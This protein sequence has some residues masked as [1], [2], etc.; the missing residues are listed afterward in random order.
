MIQQAITESKYRPIVIPKCEPDTASIGH[1]KQT[2]VKNETSVPN[3]VPHN[4][5]FDGLKVVSEEYLQTMCASEDQYK[6][7]I[8]HPRLVVLSGETADQAYPVDKQKII[9]GRNKNAHIQLRDKS[10]S[11]YHA[12][13]CSEDNEFILN[14]LK[15]TNGTVVNGHCIRG[16]K[17]LHDGDKI[18]I[19]ASCFAFVN[20]NE[21][22]VP[23]DRLM[24]R[25][26]WIIPVG[27]AVISA[28]MAIVITMTCVHTDEH[29]SA[30]GRGHSEQDNAILTTN[31]LKATGSTN[32]PNS[33][34]ERQ[35][36]A[37]SAVSPDRQGRQL[38]AKAVQ[39]YING[40]LES[41]YRMLADVSNLNLPDD[42]TIKTQALALR[43]KIKSIHGLYAKGL[44]AYQNRDLASALDIWAQ[45]L[46]ADQEIVGRKSSFFS[47]QI[48]ALTGDI[49]YTAALKSLDEGQNEKAKELCSQAFRA[50]ENHEGCAAILSTLAKS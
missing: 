43:D 3:D 36:D 22:S 35:G 17:R 2:T 27:L 9:I 15:S 11:L 28:I 40:N 42:D 49:F 7:W 45:V 46:S 41:T 25:K 4:G 26:K 34:L 20:E 8:H 24:N 39:F 19:G 16:P 32:A 31:H 29:L 21:S 18:H 5:E 33:A 48:A 44:E 1:C 14:D 12:M 23:A 47:N 50:Q 30:S 37:K 10:I 38:T 13:I 6:D